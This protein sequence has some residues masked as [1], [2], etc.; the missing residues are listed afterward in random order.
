M[1]GAWIRSPLTWELFWGMLSAFWESAV[2]RYLIDFDFSSPPPWVSRWSMTRECL[3]MWWFVHQLLPKDL[4]C[5]EFRVDLELCDDNHNLSC[6]T[7]WL[8][9]SSLNSFKY[10]HC[11]TRVDVG[12]GSVERIFLPLKAQLVIFRTTVVELLDKR[13]KQ[14]KGLLNSLTVS[15]LSALLFPPVH[16][17]LENEGYS[18]CA[19]TGISQR[20]EHILEPQFMISSHKRQ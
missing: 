19:W 12:I 1:T 18:W 20:I 17:W 5:L 6:G 2:E 8:L 4:F 10:G 9:I 16:C 15:S 13:V 14:E 3:Q 7:A 11:G